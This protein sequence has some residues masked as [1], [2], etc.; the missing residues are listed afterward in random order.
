MEVAT[1]RQLIVF[2]IDY[3]KIV[4]T[5]FTAFMVQQVLATGLL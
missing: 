5:A 3:Q 1:L 4:D 2:K